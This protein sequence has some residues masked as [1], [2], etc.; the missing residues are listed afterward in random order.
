MSK[1]TKRKSKKQE[2][3]K[4]KKWFYLPMPIFYNMMML[5]LLVFTLPQHTT[6][7]DSEIFKSLGS[8]IALIW[9]LGTISSILISPIA[10]EFFRNN[11]IKMILQNNKSL[12]LIGIFLFA[13]VAIPS[14]M[15]TGIQDLIFDIAQ[16]EMIA[17]LLY[18]YN[19][20]LIY[21]V[22]TFVLYF[23]KGRI[24]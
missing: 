23:S 4:I 8:S 1:K 11:G 15:T 16:R 9:I 21:T 13:S 20:G 19:V 3:A 2:P 18:S 12:V 22:S 14:L 10:Y 24:S 6:N 17:P 7:M 5:V